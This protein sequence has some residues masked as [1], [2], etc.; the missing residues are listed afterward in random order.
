MLKFK[1]DTLLGA[2]FLG[3][4]F[5]SV[6]NKPLIGIFKIEIFNYLD[7]I[8]FVLCLLIIGIVLCFTKKVKSIYLLVFG[9]FIYSIIISMLFGYNRI[10]GKVILQTLINIKFFIFLLTFIVLFQKKFTKI[11]T[12]FNY[13]LAFALIGFVLNVVLGSTFNHFFNIP[14]FKRPNLPMRYGGFLNP[15]HM[16]FLMVMT[17]GLILNRAKKS[18]GLL[19]NKDW[20]I[21]LGSILVILLTDSRTAIVGVLIFFVSFYWFYLIRNTKILTT[22]LTLTIVFTMFLLLYTDMWETLIINIQG[23]FSLDSYYIRGIIMNMAVQINYLYFPIGTGAATFGSVLSE[24]SEVYEIFGVAKR[25]FFIE[26]RGIYD[27]SIASIMGEYGVIGII[28]YFVIFKKLKLYL[29]SFTNT[30]KNYMINALIATFLFFS[31]TN[32]TFTNNI[33]ILLS[34]PVFI[35][36]IMPYERNKK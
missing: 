28:F 12:F 22:F 6:F 35:I 21:I 27:S 18:S 26:K 31:F 19:T 36:F 16:A 9:F 5:I 20:V 34:V 29:L 10:L 8:I 11:R 7:E 14:I 24:G 17:L 30:N 33:Y 23:S 1:Y 3:L 13:V 32:P 4:A 2:I 25:S 15:N